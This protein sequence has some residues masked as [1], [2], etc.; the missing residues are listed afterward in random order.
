MPKPGILNP[1]EIATS[2]KKVD[3]METLLKMQINPSK[4]SGLILN[5]PL[6]IAALGGNLPGVKLLLSYGTDIGKFNLHRYTSFL[7]A[8]ESGSRETVEFFY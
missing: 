6:H 3:S 8:M 2:L 5:T 7:T 1:L 4:S